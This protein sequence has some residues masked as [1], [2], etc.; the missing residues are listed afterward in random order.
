MEKKEVV[1]IKVNHFANPTKQYYGI[2]NRFPEGK[3]WYYSNHTA[4]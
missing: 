1:P 2:D 4:G 3:A